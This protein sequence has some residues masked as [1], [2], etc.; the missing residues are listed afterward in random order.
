MSL[1]AAEI[2]SIVFRE[3][4]EGSPGYDDGDVD[5]FVAGVAE[6][7][8]RL[9]AENQA[10]AEHLQESDPAGWLR[11]LERECALAQERAA[12]LSAELEQAR[13][14][15]PRLLEFAQRT[16]DGHVAEARREASETLR[17]AG[18][19]ADRLVSDA[20]LRASTLVA[21]ARHAHAERIAALTAKRAETLD[22]IER[23]SREARERLAALSAEVADRLRG[24][25][26]QPK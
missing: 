1:T 6:E 24:M 3:S 18:T 7:V 14:V 4:P 15:A 12:A 25:D 11:R 13:F 16:A 17:K 23:L 9:E 5:E 19:E 2:G 26:P 20:E 10:L 21:D 8:R 22:R